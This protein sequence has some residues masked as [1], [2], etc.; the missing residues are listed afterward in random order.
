[1]AD[2]DLQF[3]PN[4]GLVFCREYLLEHSDC[5]R[6]ETEEQE[7]DYILSDCPGQIEV[8]THLTA[9]EQLV[10]QLQD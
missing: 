1:M 4:G 3:G 10:K 2:V 9:M 7:D 5:L 6:N 8:H